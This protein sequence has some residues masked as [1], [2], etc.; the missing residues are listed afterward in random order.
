ML[1]I[2]QWTK[3]TAKPL[4]ELFCIVKRQTSNLKHKKWRRQYSV[5]E[6]DGIYGSNRG[7]LQDL[8]GLGSTNKHSSVKRP[9]WDDGIW[10]KACRKVRMWTSG[11]GNNQEQKSRS[12]NVS[13]LFKNWQGICTGTGKGGRRRAVEGGKSRV[14][15]ESLV[16]SVL[17]SH[18]STLVF[19]LSKMWICWLV[20][21]KYIKGTDF[22]C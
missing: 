2:Y 19:T 8:K 5:L 22:Y 3:Q 7:G 11:R 6:S 9:H 13:A 18:C 4:W 16:M 1:G 21:S 10:R 15:E 20:L 17:L 14:N 12:R